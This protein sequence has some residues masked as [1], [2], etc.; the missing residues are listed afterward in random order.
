MNTALPSGNFGTL[1]GDGR[2]SAKSIQRELEKVILE[3]T[4][5]HKYAV[6][7]YDAYWCERDAK[8]CILMEYMEHGSLVD[9]LGS[10]R[11]SSPPLEAFWVEDVSHIAHAVCTVLAVVS[12]VCTTHLQILSGLVELQKLGL[13]HND[14]KPANILVGKTGEVK[15]SDFGVARWTNSISVAGS[16]TGTQGYMAPEKLKGLDYS[17]QA[18]VYSAGLTL[19]Y[20]ALGKYPVNLEGLTPFDALIV[21]VQGVALKQECGLAPSLHSLLSACLDCDWKAR[22]QAEALLSFDFFHEFPPPDVPR[23][24]AVLNRE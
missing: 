8:L 4:Q 20:C 2:G 18:D 13:V 17:Y 15:I 6:E 3:L 1:C 11:G 23:F 7:S 24:L 9:V 19:A 12:S 21:I 10:L 5:L 14:I 22:P 16:G